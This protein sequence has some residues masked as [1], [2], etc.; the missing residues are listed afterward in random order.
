M[1][2]NHKNGALGKHYKDK[3]NNYII[4]ICKDCGVALNW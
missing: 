4:S 1:K 2:C 3:N